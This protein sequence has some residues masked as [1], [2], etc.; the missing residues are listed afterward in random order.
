MRNPR[1]RKNDAAVAGDFCR[2]FG[3]IAV[4]KGFVTGDQVKIALTEQVDDNLQGREHRLLG[5]ILFDRGWITEQQIE[6][7]LVTLRDAL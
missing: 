3:A 2:R 4:H 1:R 5:S 7:I 6:Q